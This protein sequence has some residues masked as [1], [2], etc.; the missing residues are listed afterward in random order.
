MKWNDIINGAFELVG[1]Y[2]TWHNYFQ[3]R[4]DLALKGI[5]WPLIAFMTTWGLWNII[6]Y[7]SLKQWFSFAGG[8]VLVGGNALW[9]NLALKIRYA[10]HSVK[11][12]DDNPSP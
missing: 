6:Y 1:A 4:K 8:V 12:P 11:R 2:F 9:L 5:W 7:P 10:P 3:L